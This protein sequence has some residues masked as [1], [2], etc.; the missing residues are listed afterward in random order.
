[1]MPACRREP[2]RRPRG[3]TSRQS[4][5]T[6]LFVHGRIA[7]ACTSCDARTAETV[8]T[9]GAE[10]GVDHGLATG[11]PIRHVGQPATAQQCRRRLDR[12]NSTCE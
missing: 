3:G 11:A 12:T 8:E 1:M 9:G 7:Y 6:A 10:D 4:R 2:P 5:R